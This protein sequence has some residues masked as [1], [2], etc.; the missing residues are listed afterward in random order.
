MKSLLSIKEAAKMIGVSVS[1]LRRWDGSGYF[2]A[3]RVGDSKE[4]KHK[5]RKYR[6]EDVEKLIE[7]SKK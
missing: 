7:K 2:K 6:P 5:H 3:I 4:L 1:T